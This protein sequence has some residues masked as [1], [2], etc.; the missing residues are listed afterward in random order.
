M[1]PVELEEAACRVV[2][3]DADTILFDVVCNERCDVVPVLMEEGSDDGD[4]DIRT[5]LEPVVDVCKLVWLLVGITG[6]DVAD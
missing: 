5:L 2:L 1:G 6:L 4:V 3:P